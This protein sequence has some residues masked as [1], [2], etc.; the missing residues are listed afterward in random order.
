[1]SRCSLNESGLLSRR[2]KL[3]TFQVAFTLVFSAWA[4]GGVVNWSR[5]IIYGLVIIGFL[6]LFLPMGSELHCREKSTTS[7]ENFIA[8]MKFPVFWLGLLLLVYILIGYLNPS[9]TFVHDGKVWWVK[10][11]NNPNYKSWLPTSVRAPEFY[12]NPT[13]YLR[14]FGMGLLF[15]CTCWVGMK[16]SASSLRILK[17]LVISGCVLVI[18]AIIQKS[19]DMRKVLWIYDWGERPFLGSF[20]YE[21]HGAAYFYILISCFMVLSIHF[22]LKKNFLYAVGMVLGALLS[23]YLIYRSS[24]HTGT[25]IG[26]VIFLVGLFLLCIIKLPL[27]CRV[28]LYFSL[29]IIT[30]WGG[31][32]IIEVS[33]STIRKILYEKRPRLEVYDLTWHFFSEQAWL[34][35]G[36]DSFALKFPQMRDSDYFKKQKRYPRT[37]IGVWDRVSQSY[38]ITWENVHFDGLEYLFELGILG[39]VLLGGC[40]IFLL[41]SCFPQNDIGWYIQFVIYLLLVHSCIDFIFNLN[42]LLLLSIFLIIFSSKKLTLDES[43]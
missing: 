37:N 43:L 25:A 35:H 8:L 28:L 42:G 13:V 10:E 1:M 14:H 33:G 41:A 22:L 36:A 20:F 5:D 17:T 21:N 30:L 2:E 15:A 32:K 29:F 34:G 31:S 4:F 12:G 38:F 3:I 26:L 23:L 6:L 11:L 27:Y 19:L 39:S 24:A 9:M 16:Q 18:I 7:K 40:L